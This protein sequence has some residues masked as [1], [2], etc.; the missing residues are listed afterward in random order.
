MKTNEKGAV[1][2]LRVTGDLI[3]QGFRVH[4]PL[5]DSMAYD[6]VCSKDNDFFTVQVKYISARNG[7]VETTPRRIKSPTERRCNTE[8]DILAIFCPTTKE[9]YYIRVDEFNASIRLRLTPPKNN[10]KTGIK[11][12][13]DYTKLCMKDRK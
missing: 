13:K 6:L 11:Y 3:M 7:I 4:K 10:M 9:C 2:E 5:V 12:A 8:F 1:G